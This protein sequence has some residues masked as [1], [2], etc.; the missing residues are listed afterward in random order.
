MTILAQD[1]RDRFLRYV[2]IDTQSDPFS[3]TAPSTEKQKDLSQLLANELLAL[4]LADA[5]MDEFGY[6]YATLPGN[7]KHKTPV[8]CLCSHVDTAPDASGTNVK[9]IVHENWNGSD[10]V[11]PDDTTL[12]LSKEKHPELA[13]Q[14]G[15]DVIT[16]SGL[17]LLGSDDKSGVTVIMSAVKYL[18]ENP[19]LPRCPIRVL[20]TPDEEIGHGVDHVDMAKLGADFGY[21]LDSGAVGC[22]ENETFSADAM[23]LTFHGVTTHPGYA[24]NKMQNALKIAGKVL[25][26]LPRSLSPEGTKGMQGFVHPTGV[27]G[28]LE[29]AEIDFIIRDFDTKKLLAHE[30]TL[31]TLA[32]KVVDSFPGARLEVSVK[33]QYRNMYEVLKDRPEITDMAMKA[34]KLNGI[35]P[36]KGRIRGGTDGSRLTFMGLPCPNL[37]AGEHAIHSRYEW[38]SVQDM[39]KAANMLISLAGLWSKVKK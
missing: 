5:H 21:T 23:T 10:I 35:K 30:E 13:D 1:I 20:F 33:E 29:K 2:Q 22:L 38:T 39:E 9:P 4:G 34:M 26:A 12:V 14:I 28:N 8:I 25:A 18:I 24:F 36:L 17:T 37:F 16:A 7:T 6:V 32:Q 15:N 27:R 11:L 3:A 19:S 31:R